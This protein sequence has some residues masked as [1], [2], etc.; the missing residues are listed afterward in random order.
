M[1]RFGVWIIMI[2]SVQLK[3]SSS[4]STI[5]GFGT[6]VASVGKNLVDGFRSMGGYVPAGYQYSFCVFNGLQ[7]PVTIKAKS[8]KEIMGAQFSGSAKDQ[9]TINPGQSTGSQF[10][11]ISLYFEIECSDQ[12]GT[13]FSETHYQLGVRNDTTLYTY[14]TFQDEGGNSC[15]EE[16]G[17]GYSTSSEFMGIIYNNTQNVVPVSFTL[18]SKQLTIPLEPQ[19]FNY[20]TDVGTYQI[21][22]T[23]GALNFGSYGSVVVAQEGMGQAAS[24][25]QGQKATIPPTTSAAPYNY[26]IYGQTAF[27]SGMGP[28][29]FVQPTNGAMRSITPMPCYIWN[30]PANYSQATYSN[31][32]IPV[33]LPSESLWLLYTGPGWNAITQ[34][35]EQPF[36]G[37]IPAGQTV[38]ALLIRPRLQDYTGRFYLIRLRTTDPNRAQAFLKS[39]ANGTLK[40]P[41]LTYEP[42]LLTPKTISALQQ[43]APDSLGM[44]QDA[45]GTQGYVMLEDVFL[46]YGLGSG[47][48][49]YSVPAPNY[50]V[51]QMFST[52]TFLQSFSN[53][54]QIQQM[55]TT[56]QNAL[57]NWIQ[58]YFTDPASVQASMKDFLLTNGAT[59]C[60][61]T[62]KDGQKTL[63]AVGQTALNM[64][65]YGPAS[66]TQLPICAMPGQ[67][68]QTQ[69]PGGFPTSF[70][71]FPV[72]G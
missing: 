16:V 44:L 41:H 7:H 19:S 3:A 64:M 59:N 17:S 60:V 25:P 28:G 12:T 57:T 23:T 22:P 31:T 26:E 40:I 45:Q 9:M 1:K 24:A 30:Q 20:L 51:S 27:E 37:Q 14:H 34:Q 13:F 66:I 52:F 15:A 6:S 11:N 39:I 33:A 10:T 43:P 36:M 65:L 61:I 69:M 47:P 18:G 72:A 62:G 70:V 53:S 50:D 56:L 5:E 71:S 4:L 38:E 46:P 58:T 2:L 35:L 54:S 63:T 29:N 42:A 48:F 49:Y 67:N 8:M 55:A 21:R 32:L 68:Y